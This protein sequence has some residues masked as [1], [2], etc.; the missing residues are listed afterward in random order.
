MKYVKIL[1]LAAVA[2]MALMAFTASSAFA[3]GGGLYNGATKLVAGK[4]LDFTIPSGGSANLVDT[5]GNTLDKCTGSTVKGELTNAGSSTVNP[6]GTITSLTWTGC[7][8]TTTTLAPGKLQA[9]WT[10]GTTGIVKS[11][12]QIE[13]TINTV[14]F[15]SCIYGVASGTSLGTLTTNSTTTATFDANAVATRFGSNVA[16]PAT[17]KWTGSYTST[18]PDNLRIEAS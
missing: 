6:T 1:S 5:S 17:S 16:C 14:L 15:G 18:E 9:E 12:A 2:A 10:S 3:T 13:V 8:F 11:D 7:T 4:T